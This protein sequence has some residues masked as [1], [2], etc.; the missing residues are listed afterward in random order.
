MDQIHEEVHGLGPQ[1]W[2][3][4]Q[5]HRCGPLTRSVICLC[6]IDAVLIELTVG[7]NKI[8]NMLAS[9]AIDSKAMRARGII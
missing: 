5:V 4:D 8:P 2:S 1:M 9:W 7:D 3:I 6:P